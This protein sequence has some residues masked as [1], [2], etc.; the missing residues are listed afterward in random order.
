MQIEPRSSVRRRSCACPHPFRATRMK[1]RPRLATK[2][3]SRLIT[4]DAR[5]AYVQE[6]QVGQQRSQEWHIN[7]RGM[8]AH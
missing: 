6:G 3:T 7:H 4:V 1:R 5:H 2:A 8:G